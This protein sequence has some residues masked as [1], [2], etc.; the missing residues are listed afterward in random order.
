MKSWSQPTEIL[1]RFHSLRA[2]GG[3]S[4]ARRGPLPTVYSVGSAELSLTSTTSAA[5]AHSKIDYHC[6]AAILGG[7]APSAAAAG[8]DAAAA[9]MGAPGSADAAAAAAASPPSLSGSAA[10]P[11]SPAQPSGPA[12]KQAPRPGGGAGGGCAGRSHR[13]R[14]P[15]LAEI[16]LCHACSCH[17]ILRTETPPGQARH[18]GGCRAQAG[19]GQGWRLGPAAAAAGAAV[20][21][22]R[23]GG[24]AAA[25]GARA[26][27]GAGAVS[28]ACGWRK[29]VNPRGR[30]ER[31]LSAGRIYIY[32]DHENRRHNA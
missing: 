30:G 27:G 11:P 31:A 32:L 29:I 22:R 12:G 2:R 18:T 20:S 24:G 1:L 25:G 9:Y 10:P 19:Q 28:G 15:L 21:W 5:S 26:G 7:A 16:Y 8:A 23:R 13:V 17:E 3:Q 4:M 6:A 14:G